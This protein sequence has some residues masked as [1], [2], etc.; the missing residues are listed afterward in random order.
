MVSA[1]RSAVSGMHKALEKLNKAAD[2]I[3]KI[4]T[5]KDDG[6][7]PQD[8]VDIKTA[9]H[10]YKANIAVLKAQQEVDKTTLDIIA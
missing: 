3:A 7:L 5:T 2:S 1:I 8:V 4:G 9:K 6:D 10:E